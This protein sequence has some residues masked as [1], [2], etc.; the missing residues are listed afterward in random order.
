MYKLWHSIVKVCVCTAELH[1]Q[2]WIGTPRIFQPVGKTVL[3]PS[4]FIFP[5]IIW[6]FCPY[7]VKG[8]SHKRSFFV[9]LTVF[10]RALAQCTMVGCGPVQGSAWSRRWQSWPSYRG[11][12]GKNLSNPDPRNWGLTILYHLHGVKGRIPVK[13]G[14]RCV[15]SFKKNFWNWII[16]RHSF[17]LGWTVYLLS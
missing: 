5:F 13:S 10:K 7:C 11:Q 8:I 9:L 15:D 16:N 4:T 1:Q 17:G 3:H 2:Y 12:A 14:D 6:L